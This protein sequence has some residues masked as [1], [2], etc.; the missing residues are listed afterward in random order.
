MA[1]HVLRLNVGDDAFFKILRTWASEKANGNATTRE[2]IA[3]AERISGK[4]LGQIFDE[5]LYGTV[6]PAHP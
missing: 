2:F 4:P 5:W 6:R 1:L 3:L